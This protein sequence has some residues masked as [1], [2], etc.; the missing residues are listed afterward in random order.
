MLFIPCVATVAVMYQE[1]RSWRWTL[2]DVALLLGI[3]LVAGILVYQG[4]GMLGMGG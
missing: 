3:A 1:M 4:A 2:F